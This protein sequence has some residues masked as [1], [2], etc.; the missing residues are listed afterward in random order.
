MKNI[1]Y[2]SVFDIYALLNILRELKFNLK[3][4][5][6]WMEYLYYLLYYVFSVE[7]RDV[8]TFSLLKL[9]LKAHRLPSTVDNCWFNIIT[10]FSSSGGQQCARYI[11]IYVILLFCFLLNLASLGVTWVGLPVK[12]NLVGMTVHFPSIFIL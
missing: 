5:V 9:Y 7:Y 11:F 2:H 3:S 10:Y 8:D 6:W 1:E 12:T 4:Q